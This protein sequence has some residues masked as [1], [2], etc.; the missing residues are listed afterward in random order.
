MFSN[1]STNILALA[2]F[3]AVGIMA[4]DFKSARRLD[5]ESGLVSSSTL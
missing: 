5:T 3:V 2:A 4:P 1:R